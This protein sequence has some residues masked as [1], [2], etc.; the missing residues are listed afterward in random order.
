MGLV[1]RGHR[2]SRHELGVEQR[3]SVASLTSREKNV[4]KEEKRV[5]KVGGC[6]ERKP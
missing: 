1:D 4:L 3:N 5:A 6:G 2:L